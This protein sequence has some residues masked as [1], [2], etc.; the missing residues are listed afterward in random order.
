MAIYFQVILVA[1]GKNLLVRCALRNPRE[2]GLLGNAS[3]YHQ[4]HL[5]EKLV[6]HPMRVQQ[7]SS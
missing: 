4:Y 1:A 3:P 7:F 6:D 5:Q 2:K